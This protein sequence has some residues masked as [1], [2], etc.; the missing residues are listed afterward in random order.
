[1]AILLNMYIHETTRESCQRLHQE[2]ISFLG[3]ATLTGI[4]RSSTTHR[5]I[6]LAGISETDGTCYETTYSDPYGSW[7]NVFVQKTIEIKL[8][9]QMARIK[10]DSGKIILPSGT[11]CNFVDSTWIDYDSG[12]MFWKPIPTNT[13]ELK[14]YDVLYEGIVDKIEEETTTQHPTICSLT[15]ESITFA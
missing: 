13:C 10:M 5:T 1:M 11:T 9:N 7:T 2:G 8:K 3:T 15:T 12:D 6:T 14:S 4:A